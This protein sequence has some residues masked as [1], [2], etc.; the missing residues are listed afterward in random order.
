MTTST[1]ADL[2]F[3]DLFILLSK[4]GVLNLSDLFKYCPPRQKMGA[5]AKIK[6]NNLV[7]E[8]T[9]SSEIIDIYD[10][11]HICDFYVNDKSINVKFVKS[12]I[13]NKDEK[14][15]RTTLKNDSDIQV[16]FLEREEGD[17]LVDPLILVIPSNEFKTKS[18]TFKLG[19]KWFKY[20]TSEY[21]L[22]SN[23]MA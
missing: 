8:A 5:K 18:I 12:K 4:Y 20:L 16:F 6:F 2:K 3:T 13:N 9:H 14:Y 17:G 19:D 22:K 11:Q 23:I 21:N 1:E 15:W 10:Y 7:P